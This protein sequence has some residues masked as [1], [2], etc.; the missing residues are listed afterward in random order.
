MKPNALPEWTPPQVWKHGQQHT[1][2]SSSF[3]II[4]LVLG[5][6]S[7]EKRSKKGRQRT[8]SAHPIILWSTTRATGH[9]IARK[10]V[11]LKSARV[12]L[13]FI[14]QTR[15]LTGRAR[16][17]LSTAPS[18]RK[19]EKNLACTHTIPVF[20][21]FLLKRR[22][23][24]AATGSHCSAYQKVTDDFFIVGRKVKPLLP[25]FFVK[26]IE[27]DRSDC[28]APVTLFSLSLSLS[29]VGMCWWWAH[30]LHGH[31]PQRDA[32]IHSRASERVCVHRYGP[33]HTDDLWV[34]R[35]SVGRIHHERS[36]SSLKTHFPL[37]LFPSIN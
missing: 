7:N 25:Q 14:C 30:L 31:H 24:R 12:S 33:Q 15:R 10:R 3:S 17:F 21:L 32:I 19:K 36:S 16:D 9:G 35:H 11:R 34:T 8:P 29:P 28:R 5:T 2:R 6:R 18:Q 37:L 1:R 13:L 23:T 22:A 27:F 4:R 26:S 20:T